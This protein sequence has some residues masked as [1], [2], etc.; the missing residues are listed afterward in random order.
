MLSSEQFGLLHVHFELLNR[1]NERMDLTS[2][3]G[4]GEIVERHYCESLFFAGQMDQSEAVSSVID[5]GSGAGFPGL[6]LAVVHPRMQVTLLEPNQRRAVFLRESAR[7]LHN[8]SVVAERGE[9]FEGRHDMVVARA[10]NVPEV[11]RCVPRL[12]A[13][14]GLLLS[15]PA[16]PGLRG[17]RGFEWGE[18]IRVPW[19]VSRCCIFGECS[20]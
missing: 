15:D 19:S 16:L 11:L 4:A 18:N 8:V 6:P 12:G 13:R 7:G 9:K 17:T 5:F 1:W 20:T 10:V 2:V 14:I 3:D